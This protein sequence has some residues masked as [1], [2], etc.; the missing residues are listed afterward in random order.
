MFG[1]RGVPATDLETAVNSRKN[2]I[3]TEANEGNEAVEKEV[4]GGR[5]QSLGRN[6]SVG[7]D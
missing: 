7:H 1:R 4:I 2:R 5:R 3:I 6:I